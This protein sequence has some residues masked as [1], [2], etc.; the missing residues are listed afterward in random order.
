MF[1]PISTLPV[2][3]VTRP[4]SPMWSQARDVLRQLL[5]GARAARTPARPRAR[6]RKADEKTAAE[7]LQEVAAVD[8]ERVEPAMD[9][10]LEKL[11]TETSGLA[12]L[13]SALPPW[14]G[15]ALMLFLLS[16]PLHGAAGCAGTSRTGRCCRWSAADD[17]RVRGVRVAREEAAAVR[18][19]PGVQ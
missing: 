17:L 1:W 3:T 15:R 16:R 5:P 18:I 2:K 4:S 7:D 13:A 14:P 12:S 10:V 6:S 9:L 8:V 11:E 19:I